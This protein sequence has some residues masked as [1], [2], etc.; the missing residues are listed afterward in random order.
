VRVGAALSFTLALGLSMLSHGVRVRADPFH[1]QT[2]PLGH[3][4]IGMGGAF[5]AVADDPSATYYNPA[6]V[7]WG[8]DNSLSASL[9][10]T[11]FDRSTVEGGYRTSAGSSS[12]NHST[13]ASVPV[14]VSAS[15]HLGRRHKDGRR[16]HA[17][18]LSSFTERQRRLSFDAE[19]RSTTPVGDAL[20]TL[21]IDQADRT[22]WHG[23]SY[24]YRLHP[25]LSLGISSYVTVQRSH[26]AEE[27]IGVLLGTANGDGSFAASRSSWTSHLVDTNVKS[28]VGRFGALYAFNEK[29]RL[30]LMFQPPG[31]HI[32]GRARVR[33]RY[34]RSDLTEER[35]ESAFFNASQGGLAAASPIPWELR[36]GVR[37]LLRDWLVLAF[38][39]S[40]YGRSGS[41]RDPVVAIGARRADERTGAVPHVGAFFEERWHRTYS[42]NVSLGLEA[43]FADSVAVRC[44][45]YTDLSSAP[46][47]PRYASSYQAPDVHRL[48]GAFSIGLVSDGYD[49]SLGVVGLYG[50]GRALSFSDDATEPMYQRT[51]ATDRMFFVFLNGVKN[52]VRTLASKA[53][54]RLRQAL[55]VEKRVQEREAA[56]RSRDR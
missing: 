29:L 51:V 28:M 25:Q 17:I 7:V 56:T 55:E 37:Y 13:G 26:Y 38:D 14:F 44:G 5:V 48:G 33:E 32:R 24:A 9:T 23:F 40:L 30:G 3:R 27:R 4:A 36:A 50:R 18:A 41:A 53:D 1:N 31:V 15:K 11:A 8:G 34:L 35:R 43:T 42:G 21:S 49:F 54:E 46:A 45:L 6:G 47:I 22:T 20:E 16:H 12:L 52:A 2:L 19:V 10:L 39:S